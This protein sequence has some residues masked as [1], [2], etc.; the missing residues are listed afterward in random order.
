[1]SAEEATQDIAV[2]SVDYAFN[3]GGA[4]WRPGSLSCT[5]HRAAV[6]E[7]SRLRKAGRFSYVAIYGPYY[8]R[9]PA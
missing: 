8:Q 3:V 4:E 2:W 5:T 6:M 9:V 1:M 7:A